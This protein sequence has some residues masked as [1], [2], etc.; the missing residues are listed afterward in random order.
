VKRLFRIG[1]RPSSGA[2]LCR[3]PY[4]IAGV[5]EREDVNVSRHGDADA[6]QRKGQPDTAALSGLPDVHEADAL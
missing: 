5:E 1:I 4:F 2:R 3:I 6:R